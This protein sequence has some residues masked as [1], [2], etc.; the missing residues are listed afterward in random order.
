MSKHNF[1]FSGFGFWLNDYNN[2]LIDKLTTESL[3]AFC[4]KANW[5]DVVKDIENLVKEGVTDVDEIANTINEEE[6]LAGIFCTAFNEGKHGFTLGWA[7]DDDCEDC[8]IMVDMRM[9][10]EDSTPGLTKEKAIELIQDYQKI[11]FNGKTCNLEWDSGSW[12]C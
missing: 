4:K 6:G 5:D 1:G 2:S 7:H 9:P 3:I 12:Y 11:L 10:W 8:F